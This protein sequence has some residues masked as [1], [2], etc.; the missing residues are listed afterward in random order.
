MGLFDRAKI[1]NDFNLKIKKADVKT[2]EQVTDNTDWKSDMQTKDLEC[3][4]QDYL[5]DKAGKLWI[6]EHPTD[7][8]R[9]KIVQHHGMVNFYTIITNDQT[10]HDVDV[11]VC[12]KF[13]KGTGRTKTTTVTKHSNETR[14]RNERE[15]QERRKKWDARRNTTGY[16]IYKH[17]Y[18]RPVG[19]CVDTTSRLLNRASWHL[20]KL[21]RVLLFW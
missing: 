17:V 12:V 16:K 13:T 10:D 14:L 15:F 18:R 11:N 19:W 21:K 1:D 5:L 20:Q 9:R 7:K 3:W 2:I 6:Y 4:M 8:R